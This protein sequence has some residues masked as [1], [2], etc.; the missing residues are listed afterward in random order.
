MSPVAAVETRVLHDT[1]LPREA[2]L[3]AHVVSFEI[4]SPTCTS[5]LPSHLGYQSTCVLA[6]VRVCVRVRECACVRV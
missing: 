6:C 4:H 1:I 5:R 3:V 2:M